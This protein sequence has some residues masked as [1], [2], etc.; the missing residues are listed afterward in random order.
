MQLSTEVVIVQQPFFLVPEDI[1]NKKNSTG[2]GSYSKGSNTNKSPKSGK[3]VAADGTPLFKGPKGP[4]SEK[5]G[6]RRRRTRYV[7]LFLVNLNRCLQISVI[8]SDPLLQ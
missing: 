4:Q 3:D 7:M 1:E 6:P 5:G 8:T 2:R